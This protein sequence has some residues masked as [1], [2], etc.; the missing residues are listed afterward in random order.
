MLRSTLPY[1]SLLNKT[2]FGCFLTVPYQTRLHFTKQ[3]L[4][5]HCSTLF[6]GVRTGLH[7]AQ[8]HR[9]PLGNALLHFALPYPA[10]I[11]CFWTVL[12]ST[13]PHFTGE[14]WT[15]LGCVRTVLHSTSPNNTKLDFASLRNAVFGC[16]YAV[17]NCA[18]HQFAPPDRDTLDLTAHYIAALGCIKTIPNHAEQDLTPTNHTL[19]YRTIPNSIICAS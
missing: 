13:T 15:M 19:H 10:L 1:N 2:I 4:T 7:Y 17:H 16:I 12:N 3:R 9:T 8:L 11:G 6:G 5:G 18:Q 14:N